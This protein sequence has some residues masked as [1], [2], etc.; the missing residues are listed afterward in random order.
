MLKNDCNI[1]ISKL[2]LQLNSIAKVANTQHKITEKSRQNVF[3]LQHSLE[4]K[5]NY[6]PPESPRQTK[7]LGLHC[8]M[9][10]KKGAEVVRHTLLKESCRNCIYRLY[11]GEITYF[12]AIHRIFANVADFLKKKEKK[13]CCWKD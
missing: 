9:P 3:L 6:P 2:C 8:L 5:E 12:E 7:L 11:H 10:V 1:V 13:N 4:T